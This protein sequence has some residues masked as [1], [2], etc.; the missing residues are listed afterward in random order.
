[1]AQNAKEGGKWKYKEFW[2]GEGEVMG[3]TISLGVSKEVLGYSAR[4]ML[5]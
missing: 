3:S 1:M 4:V 2:F 5:G